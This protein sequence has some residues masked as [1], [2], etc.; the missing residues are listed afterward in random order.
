MTLSW[1][2]PTLHTPPVDQYTVTRNPG[3]VKYPTPDG[4]TTKLVVSGLNN[5]TLYTFTVTAHNVLGDG[6]PSAPASATPHATP[7]G[8]PNNLGATNL[9]SGQ[10]RIDW[11]PP[12]SKGSMPSGNASAID[13]YNVSVNP[14]GTKASVPGSGPL[15]YT[16]S[17]LADNVT[18]AFQVSAT[19]TRPLTGAAATV[20]APLPTGANIG[21]Q[22]TAGL[23]NTAITVTGQLF[24]KNES[25]TLY[26]DVPTHVAASVVTDD[27]GSFTKVVKPFAGDKPKVHTLYA[28]VQPK[29]HATFTLRATPTPTPG[30][31]PSPAETPTPTP[32][33]T[34]QA[35]GARPGGGISGLDIITRPPFVFLP[36]LAILGILGV[37]AYWLYSRR[38]QVPPT[39]AATV[40]H[41]AT[42]PDYM[43]PFPTAATTP[44]ATPP[45]V[46]PSAWDA[47]VQSAPPYSSPAVQPPPAQPYAPP[48][49]QPPPAQP[50]VPTPY[51][52]PPVPPQAP[53]PPPAPPAAAPRAPEWQAPQNPPAA[54]DE[55]PDLPQPS[56]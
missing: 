13:H 24:L 22:P 29:P 16:A 34:P 4:S 40:V 46:Q 19:N 45:A 18:Y 51:V 11:T 52:P 5:G 35:S 33:G 53:P 43:A 20:Y 1:A 15:T 39:S 44:S 27:T 47:P 25:I 17:G 38:R 50:Y 31:T 8:R 21:L 9:G 23:A 30:V 10:I 48:A 36:I 26:W 6:P 49:V 2:A 3:A 32:A 42:R 41:R 28:S 55:P 12:T 7:P 54:P 14:G 37:L 56:D